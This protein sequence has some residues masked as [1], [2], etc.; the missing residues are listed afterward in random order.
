MQQYSFSHTHLAFSQL[1][2]VIVL[3][4][5]SINRL[6]LQPSFVSSVVHAHLF[7]IATSAFL[8]PSCDYC[9][10]QQW[11]MS[12]LLR[13]VILKERDRE[14]DNVLTDHS[15]GKSFISFFHP[16]FS[17]SSLFASSLCLK[18]LFPTDMRGDWCGETQINRRR[19]LRAMTHGL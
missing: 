3:L 14:T 8:S 2:S 15:Q 19:A 9:F 7:H 11:N 13:L 1:A 6:C 17:L 5:Y 16:F 4:K 10:Q 18:T 12:H